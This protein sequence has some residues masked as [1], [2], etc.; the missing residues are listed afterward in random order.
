VVVAVD[1][2][3]GRVSISGWTEDTG[4]DAITLARDAAAH[5]AARILYTDILRDGGKQGPN[6]EATARMQAALP[7]TLVIASGGI[8]SLD[9]LRAL[10]AAGVRCCVVGKALYDGA[11]TLSQA[12]AAC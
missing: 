1:A 11:F 2:R 9:D 3:D 5:G 10:A 4:V 8:G 7:D 6:V 12:L